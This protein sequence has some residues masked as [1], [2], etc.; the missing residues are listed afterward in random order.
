[1]ARRLVLMPVLPRV[2]VS[3]AES[4]FCGERL[5]GDGLKIACDESQVAPAVV[6]DE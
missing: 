2:T 4:E 1:M 6:A 5:F 3:K